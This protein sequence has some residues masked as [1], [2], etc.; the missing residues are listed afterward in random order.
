VAARQGKG[1]SVMSSRPGHVHIAAVPR[2]PDAGPIGWDG[3]E[4]RSFWT[5]VSPVLV[6][7]QGSACGTA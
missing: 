7:P 2:S 6:K 4:D 5:G 1:G 3:A